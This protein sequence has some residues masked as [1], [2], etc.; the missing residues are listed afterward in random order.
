MDILAEHRAY[1][2]HR[3]PEYDQWWRREGQY[4][5]DD[6][7]RAGWPADVAAVESAPDPTGKVTCSTA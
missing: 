1:Y 3:A 6:Q 7:A 2:R 5:L 4:A